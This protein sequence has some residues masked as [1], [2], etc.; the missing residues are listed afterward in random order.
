[1]RGFYCGAVGSVGAVGGVVGA[2]GLEG[3]DPGDVVPGVNPLVEDGLVVLGGV[4][5]A[6]PDKACA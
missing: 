2:V 3:S 5:P 6:S 1:M 4:P